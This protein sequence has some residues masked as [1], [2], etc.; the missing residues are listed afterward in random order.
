ME[1]KTMKAKGK[2]FL[3]ISGIL[4]IIAGGISI[5]VAIILLI[6]IGILLRNVEEGG[7]IVSAF[8]TVSMISGVV[9]IIASAVQVVTGLVG[10]KNARV[11]EHYKRCK[12]WGIVVLVLEGIG[13]I[14]DLTGAIVFGIASNEI[15][16]DGYSYPWYSIIISVICGVVIPV[17]FI[18]GAGLNK[19]SYLEG[20]TSKDLP[21]SRAERKRAQKIADKLKADDALLVKD[22]FEKVDEE[23]AER[24]KNLESNGLGITDA[25][26]DTQETNSAETKNDNTLL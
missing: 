12:V 14:L 16:F 15:G 24:L 3:S 22:S 8:S 13:I 5:I 23:E 21:M 18:V 9:V 6:L 25:A 17:I 20:V 4:M 19:Q 7:F 10:V 2:N 11:P 26:I 1:T